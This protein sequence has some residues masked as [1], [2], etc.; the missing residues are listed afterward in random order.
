LKHELEFNEA[1]MN[2]TKGAARAPGTSRKGRIRR[3]QRAATP[4]TF[5]RDIANVAKSKVRPGVDP[6]VLKYS[7]VDANTFN[8]TL[9]DGGKL[10]AVVR[11]DS[12]KGKRGGY[13]YRLIGER[14][15]HSGFASMRELVARVATKI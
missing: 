7:R 6:K 11:K 8:I 1:F 9:R 2:M 5:S 13:S 15:G 14:K 3:N 4:V 10:I 12:G